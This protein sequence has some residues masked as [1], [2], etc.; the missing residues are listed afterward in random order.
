[1][2]INQTYA[3]KEK[4]GQRE[5][6]LQYCE[7]FLHPLQWMLT[8]L[9]IIIIIFISILQAVAHSAELVCKGPSIYKVYAKI[10]QKSTYFLKL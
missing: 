9:L 3:L 4:K 1:M 10:L 8:V 7:F 5:Q 6:F 2:F